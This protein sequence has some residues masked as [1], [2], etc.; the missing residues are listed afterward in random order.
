MAT[1]SHTV[2][3][4]LDDEEYGLLSREAAQ[5]GVALDD[6]AAEKLRGELGTVHAADLDAI[7]DDLAELRKGLP[8]ADAAALVR[9]GRDQRAAR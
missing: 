6:L 7:L 9:A 3:V 1:G 2:T 8:P 5:R 4:R